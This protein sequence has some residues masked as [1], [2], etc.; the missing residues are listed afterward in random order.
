MYQLLQASTLTLMILAAA[1]AEADRVQDTM[2]GLKKRA[3]RG[4]VEEVR[5]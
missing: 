1:P 5:V 3:I 4:A 2:T